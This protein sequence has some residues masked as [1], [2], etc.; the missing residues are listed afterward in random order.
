VV[1]GLVILAALT[2][3][4]AVTVG[5]DDGGHLVA[6]WVS[7]TGRDV[8]ANHHAPAF[9]PSAGEAGL[10]Y[11]PVSDDGGPAGRC[12]LE[13]L[14]A[15]DGG[16]VWTYDLPPEACFIHAVADPG[17]ADVD[18]DGDREVLAA[19]AEDELAVFDAA[20][21]RRILSTP[22]T[23]YGYTEPVFAD[24]A[25][26][27]GRE[28]VVVDATG[29]LHVVGV[30]GEL[31]W[32]RSR[33]A[34]VWA[35]PAVVDAD[36]DGRLEV[37]V[38]GRDGTLAVYEGDGSPAWERSGLGTVS[39]LGSGDG[40]RDGVPEVYLATID[41][42]VLAVDLGD[43]E[44]E[45]RTRVGAFAAVGPPFDGD[46][47]GSPEVYATTK[48]GTL[49]ALDA[50]SGEVAWRIGLT[51]ESVQMMPP[52]VRGDVD[53]DGTP[54]LVAAAHDG[55]VSVVDPATGA[56]RATYTRETR[57]F[58]H[59]VPADVD[60]DGDDEALVLYADGRVVALDYRT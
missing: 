43:G 1:A 51:P 37:A 45:W 59:A 35:Q 15:R 57:L 6:A 13:A 60:G 49:S 4:L 10:V 39:W 26:A 25:P 50:A 31:R 54:E 5:S 19:T 52:P 46:G 14:D 7:E 32:S 3:V 34:Y 40:D 42:D 17:L 38:A 33:G 29:T 48:D 8:S 55:S 24:L 16:T 30:D 2:G 27:P 20:T 12:T 18:G 47:D 56:V 44:L 11:A 23:D 22:L 58:T 36:G 21:G 41:G 53:G 9:D 28:F